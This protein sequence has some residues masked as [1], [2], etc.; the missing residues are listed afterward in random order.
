LGQN[1]FASGT[2]SFLFRTHGKR[3][4]FSKAFCMFSLTTFTFKAQTVM[5]QNQFKNSTFLRMVTRLDNTYV[6]N[7]EL[8]ENETVYLVFETLDSLSTF[9]HAFSVFNFLIIYICS[10]IQ[11]CI[12]NTKIT[13]KKC[14]GKCQVADR[15]NSAKNMSRKVEFSELNLYLG[16]QHHRNLCLAPSHLAFYM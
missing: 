16:F 13:S 14:T 3:C 4:E 2:P 10:I 1:N 7:A 8:N 6:V 9:T 12:L 15:I 5:K 11:C